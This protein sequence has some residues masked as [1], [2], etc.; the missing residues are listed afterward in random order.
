MVSGGLKDRTGEAAMPPWTLPVAGVIFLVGLGLRFYNLGT[1][2]FWYDEVVTAHVTRL[3]TLGGTIGFVQ[4]WGDHA[5]LT[6]I[7]TWLLRGLGGDEWAV[8]LPFALAGTLSVGAL[9]LLGRA[10]LP[11]RAALAATLFMAVAPFAVY[12]GQEARLYS[13]LMLFTSLQVLFAYRA[14]TRSSPWDWLAL[15]ALSIIILYTGYLGVFTTAVAFAF[16]GLTLVA[17]T[18]RAW[19]RKET[20]TPVSRHLLARYLLVGL[21]ALLTLLAYLP[22][23]PRLQAFLARGD[24]G[25]GRLSGYNA[26]GYSA[27]LGDVYSLFT[28]LN[29]GG[30]ILFLMGVGLVVSVAWAIRGKLEGWLVLIWAGLPLIV[31]VVAGG[32]AIVTLP[33]RYFSFL[34]PLAMLLT[35]LGVHTIAEGATRLLARYKAL[36]VHSQ[37]ASIATFAIITIIVLAQSLPPLIEQYARPKAEFREAARYTIDSSPPGSVVMVIGAVNTRLLPPFVRETVEYY[38]QFWGAPIRVIDGTRLDRATLQRIDGENADLWLALFTDPHPADIESAAVDKLEVHKFNSITMVRVQ[39]PRVSAEEQARILLRWG[40]S[41]YPALTSTRLLF[42]SDF[43]R[44]AFGDNVLPPADHVV[45]G[46]VAIPPVLKDTWIPGPGS[47]LNASDNSFTLAPGGGTAM[48]M[49]YTSQVEAGEIYVLS[50]RCGNDLP[51]GEARVYVDTYDTAGTYMETLPEGYGY[52]CTPGAGT[53]RQAT[54]FRATN[55]TSTLRVR[56]VATGTGVARF[57]DL[58]LRPLR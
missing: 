40:T 46:P 50:F 13:Y 53:T 12:Y 49:L 33:N 14:A 48:V 15:T 21:S 4:S 3:D 22:W 45:T 54:A 20:Q 38:Y 6:F 5:P 47:A 26:A 42:D 30:L 18:I 51:A 55:G 28:S 56:L 29:L 32:S 19:R 43:E 58:E 2:G 7:V 23:L 16:V 52:L 1:H 34:F 11:M 24:L 57:G 41:I 37:K 10:I 35:G 9:F 31:F 8:R 39:P 36:E 44:S 17:Q 25:F 27:T